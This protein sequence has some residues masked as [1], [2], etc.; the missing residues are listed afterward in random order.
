MFEYALL[1]LMSAHIHV[2][3]IDKNKNKQ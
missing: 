2:Y 3:N 1:T